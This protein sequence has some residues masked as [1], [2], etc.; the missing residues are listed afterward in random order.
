MKKQYRVHLTEIRKFATKLAGQLRG[1]EILALIG[2]LG[3][4][5]TTFTQVLAAGLGVKQKVLSPTFIVLQD[6]P[7][8]LVTRAGQ[9]VSLSHLDLYRTKN[10]TEVEALGL[11]QTW[12]QPQ[13]ITVIEWADKIKSSLPSSTIYIYLSRNVI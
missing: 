10:F 6:F 9:K 5:K 13:T 7:T 4:G 11:T 8:K 3:S 1:S 2:P 12:G